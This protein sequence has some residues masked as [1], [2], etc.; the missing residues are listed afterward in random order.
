MFEL[1]SYPSY[2][3]RNSTIHEPHK[4][5]L[6]LMSRFLGQMNDKLRTAWYTILLSNVSMSEQHSRVKLQEEIDSIIA[7]ET[8]HTC[9]QKCG[10][11][12]SHKDMLNYINVVVCEVCSIKWLESHVPHAQSHPYAWKHWRMC[13]H[14]TNSCKQSKHDLRVCC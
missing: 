6:L 10:M 14:R 8:F 4:V 9:T 13:W 2:W 1:W 3:M 11:A 5:I 7:M 12:W